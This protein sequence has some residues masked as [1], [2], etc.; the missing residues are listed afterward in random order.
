MKRLVIAVIALAVVLAAAYGIGAARR[1]A[2]YRDLIEQGDA[3]LA[4]GDVSAAIESFSGAVL[5]KDGAMVGYLKRGESY[6][7]RG[8]FDAALRDLRRAMELDPTATRPRELLGDVNYAL[9]RYVRAAERYREFL[10]LDDRSPRVLYKLGLALH[11]AGQPGAAIESLRKAIELEED[12]PE[13]HYVLGLCLREA[14]QPKAALAVLE[15]AVA[16]APTLLHA[17]E[18]L[19]D[20]Y[21]RVGRPDSRIRQLDA[22]LALDPR[23]SREVALGQA[24]AASGDQA[25]AVQTL[26]RALRRYP[27]YRYT[28]VALGRVW[29]EDAEARDDRVALGKAV[30]ALESAAGVADTSETL[31]LLGRAQLLSG[32]VPLAERTLQQATERLPVDPLA[33]FYLADAAERRGH[34]EIARGALIDFHAL[35]GDDGNRRRLSRLSARVADL[36]MQLA[37]FST[38]AAWYQRAADAT[39]QDPSLLVRL[40]EAQWRAGRGDAARATV[41]KALEIDPA[42]VSAAALK[43]RIK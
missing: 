32:D 13:A 8:D 29:L 12:L 11:Q 33:F 10:A 40:A 14:Q 2:I 23:P 9:E 38:A 30:E 6:R 34:V 25:S 35:D 41:G 27:G 4:G 26:V 18:E 21:G 36:S 42:H 17:R 22:L 7:R 15:R 5:L 3:A 1:D 39:P 28:Y 31:M 20:L 19:A 24:Y 37:D 16:L 43:A